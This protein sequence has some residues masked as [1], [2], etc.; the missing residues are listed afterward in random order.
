MFVGGGSVGVLVGTGVSDGLGFVGV[1]V[2]E[3]PGVSE[4]GG[5]SVCSGVGVSVLEGGFVGFDLGG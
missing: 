3:A 5:V 2:A 4:I 1:G